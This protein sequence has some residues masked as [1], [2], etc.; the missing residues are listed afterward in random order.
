MVVGPERDLDDWT[1]GLGLLE[2]Y[3]LN[4]R[5]SIV[6]AEWARDK[7][8]VAQIF[9]SDAEFKA[10][11]GVLDQITRNLNSSLS[12]ATMLLL[13]RVALRSGGQEFEAFSLRKLAMVL[14]KERLPAM[15][16]RLRRNVLPVLMRAG[17]IQGFEEREEWSTKERKIRLTNAGLAAQVR[18]LSRCQKL[19][20]PLDSELEDLHR[21][22]N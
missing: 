9:R 12:M 2:A 7:S 3:L 18:Y 10:H 6:L 14:D 15:E 17:Y 5:S 20:A 8:E 16:R 11:P 22:K 1:D 4:E 13:A 19:C 21:N